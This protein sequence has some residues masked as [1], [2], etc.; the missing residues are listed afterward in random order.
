MRQLHQRR[1][2]CGNINA[3]GSRQ[4][5]AGATASR[6]RNEEHSRTLLTWPGRRPFHI[7][8]GVRRLR[9]VTPLDPILSSIG[10][11]HSLP[12]DSGGA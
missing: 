6:P 7:A 4:F 9:M 8:R 1:R 12:D 10:Q 5:T 11:R 2:M 3:D